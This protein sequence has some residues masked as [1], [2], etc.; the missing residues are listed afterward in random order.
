MKK[1]STIKISQQF[2]VPLKTLEKCVTSYNKYFHSFD[3]N[4]KTHTQLI[5][6]LKKKFLLYKETMKF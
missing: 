1:H 4:Y 6:D 5:D 2:D 3:D